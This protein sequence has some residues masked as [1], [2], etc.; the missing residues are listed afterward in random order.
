MNGKQ[1][2]LVALGLLLFVCLVVWA[3]R[4]VPETPQVNK[5]QNDGPKVMSYDNNTI[6][7]EKDGVKIWDLTADHIDVD[8]DTR[9]AEMTG[10]TGHFYQQDGRSAEVKAD[11]ASYD[12][13][14]KDIEIDGNVIITT[15]DGAELTSDQLLWTAEQ[16]CSRLSVRP[17]SRMIQ[18]GPGAIASTVRTDSRKSRFLA[19]PILRNCWKGR[20]RNNEEW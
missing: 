6:S 2:A 10:I 16:Q 8:I 15:S 7:E 19:R 18:S 1:K 14:S 12:N 13:T 20:R 3:V 17:R 9:N 5:D 11:H 4:T